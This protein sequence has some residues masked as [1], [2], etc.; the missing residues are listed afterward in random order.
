MVP[1]VY[2]AFFCA[3]LQGGT[4]GVDELRAVTALADG[5][6]VLAGNTAGESKNPASGALL[7]FLFVREAFFTQRRACYDRVE[8]A[9][10][11]GWSCLR[12][13]ALIGLRW[14]GI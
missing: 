1:V 6:I 12:N 7:V 8:S 13:S 10:A 9:L 14:A 4:A 2:L 11:R 3:V 5:T